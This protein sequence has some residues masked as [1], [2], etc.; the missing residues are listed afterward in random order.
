MRHYSGGTLS[1]SLF[2]DG[3]SLTGMG[4]WVD[5]LLTKTCPD[6]SVVGSLESC[7]ETSLPSSSG[8]LSCGAGFR[9]DPSGTYC[10]PDPGGTDYGAHTPGAVPN[11]DGCVAEMGYQ[12]DP[13]NPKYCVLTAAAAKAS[14]SCKYD[15]YY[16]T[17]TKKCVKNPEL[18]PAKGEQPCP[19]GTYRPFGSATCIKTPAP[20]PTSTGGG[21]VVKTVTPVTTTPVTPTQAGMFGLSPFAIGVGLLVAVGGAVYYRRRQKKKGGGMAKNWHD[22]DAGDMGWELAAMSIFSGSLSGQTL[23]GSAL[24]GTTL[25]GI[26]LEGNTLHDTAASPGPMKEGP[27]Q[28][29]EYDPTCVWQK[30]VFEKSDFMGISPQSLCDKLSVLPFGENPEG[31]SKA[32]E[33]KNW[34]YTEFKPVEQFCGPGYRVSKAGGCEIDPANPPVLKQDFCM[35]GYVNLP[36]QGCVRKPSPA[37]PAIGIESSGKMIVGAVVVLGI[38][39]ALV[40]SQKKGKA[41]Y[42]LP[43]TRRVRSSFGVRRE[44]RTGPFGLWSGLAVQGS[45]VRYSHP[46]TERLGVR[47]RI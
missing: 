15:E 35:E 33:T 44:D 36:G 25:A 9:P 3:A 43:W 28:S 17:F 39:A 18:V 32:A 24:A 11:I 20:K 10:E 6:G 12:V 27:C 19:A 40:A 13:K 8:P 30:D 42:E 1:G 37:A 5:D 38:V 26:T 22:D 21:G 45:V 34:P 16:D 29:A 41:R 4:D 46:R 7:P 2:S 31:C 47:L 23:A 14:A